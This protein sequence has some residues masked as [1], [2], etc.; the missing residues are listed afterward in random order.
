MRGQLQEP[1]PYSPKERVCMRLSE[2]DARKAALLKIGQAILKMQSVEVPAG[3][4]MAG[5]SAVAAFCQ[6]PL[7]DQA[8]VASAV[9]TD[10]LVA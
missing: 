7:H 8:V 4:C 2:L 5:F 9:M 3:H 10:G 1:P 6:I